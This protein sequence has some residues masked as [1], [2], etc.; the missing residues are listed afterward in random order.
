[1]PCNDDTLVIAT[2]DDIGTA[3]VRAGIQVARILSQIGRLGL[4]VSVQKTE[5][6]VFYGRTRPDVLPSISVGGTRIELKESMKYLGVFIDSRWSFVDH[7]AYVTDKVSKV[8]R[9]LGRLMPNLKGPRE[10][11]RN[12]YSKVIQSVILYGAPIWC[13]AFERSKRVQ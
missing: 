7:F 10:D 5:A 4:R 9:A 11:K 6:V 1:M 12:L 2:A 13:D 8:T 3:A